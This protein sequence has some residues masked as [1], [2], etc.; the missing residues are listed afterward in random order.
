MTYVSRDT[1]KPGPVEV[2]GFDRESDGAEGPTTP[3]PGGHGHGGG[4]AGG[5]MNEL[6]AQFHAFE[7][8]EE[9]KIA[10]LSF[11]SLLGLRVNNSGYPGDKPSGTQWWNANNVLAVTDR[12]LF[13]RLDTFGGQ[14]GSPVWRFRDGQRHIVAVHNTGGPVFNGSVRL[15]KPVFDNL[16]GWKNQYT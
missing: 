7:L 8:A 14:S 6:L 3:A 16:V 12:R 2:A 11:T 10:N 13:Y 1:L 9:A 5:T 15:V 4:A